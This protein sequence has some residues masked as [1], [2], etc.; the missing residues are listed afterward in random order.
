MRKNLNSDLLGSV[1]DDV[2][3]RS[4][5]INEWNAFIHVSA[6]NAQIRWLSDEI[7]HPHQAGTSVPARP[8]T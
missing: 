1:P 6:K 8:L 7:L 5:W 3:V 4:L 2:F